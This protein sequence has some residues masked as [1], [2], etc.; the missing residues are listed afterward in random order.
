MFSVVRRKTMQ[1]NQPETA[2]SSRPA[3]APAGVSWLIGIGLLLGPAI[4]AL[5]GAATKIDAL[6]IACPLAGGV[7]SG[8][9]FGIMVARRFG[10]TVLSKLLLGLVCAVVF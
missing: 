3:P 6:A 4:L 8:I 10:K 2:A 5:I 7:I 9:I 1:T